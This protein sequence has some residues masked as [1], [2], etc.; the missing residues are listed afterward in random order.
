MCVAPN[1]TKEIFDRLRADRP[2][3][4]RRTDGRTLLYIHR[5]AFIATEKIFYCQRRGCVVV[6]SLGLLDHDK[7]CQKISTELKNSSG[8]RL[9]YR[10]KT[11]TRNSASV[12]CRSAFITRGK[13]IGPQ[14][15]TQFRL[16][17]STPT[18]LRPC[19]E[20]SIPSSRA[21]EC[22]K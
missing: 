11:P 1:W 2:T 17:S 4:D 18:F 19:R 14:G 22:W 7:S 8:N 12:N 13:S 9:A 20:S 21:N 16:M 5:V 3:S 10:Q 15:T 6:E